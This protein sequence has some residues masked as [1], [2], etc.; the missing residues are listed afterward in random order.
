MFHEWTVGNT[1]ADLR[2]SEEQLQNLDVN[3]T[4]DGKEGDESVEPV[5][6]IGWASS[7]SSI[8]AFTAEV[9]FCC[10]GHNPREVINLYCED[11]PEFWSRCV[12]SS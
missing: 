1:V 6:V 4:A 7:E 8:T 3:L 9:D 2:L 10:C 11:P 12:S 5:L